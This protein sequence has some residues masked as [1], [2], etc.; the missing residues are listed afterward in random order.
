IRDAYW[1]R[2]EVLTDLGSYAEALQDWDRAIALAAAEK[3][4][5]RLYRALTR[6][7]SG[8]HALAVREAETLSGAMGRSAEALYRL[9]CV[10]ALAGESAAKD[11]AL[12]PQDQQSLADRYGIRAV[13]LLRNARKA[14]YFNIAAN[15]IKLAKDTDLEA[16]RPR[17]DFQKLR[18]ELGK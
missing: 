14:G 16:V 7:R 8:R 1:K 2:A 9:A 5:F 13:G 15:R 4:W 10:F 12:T 11:G 17:P 3:D 18:D 6:A